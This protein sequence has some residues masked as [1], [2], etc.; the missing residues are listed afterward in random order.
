VDG[1]PGRAVRR[2][3]DPAERKARNRTVLFL[4]VLALINA[5]VFL[6]R[7]DGGL[8]GFGDTPSAAI[9]RSG[10]VL[11]PVADPVADACTGDPVRI[12]EGL[13]GLIALE[14][15]L[16]SGA[17]LR[18]ALLDRGVAS[19]EV[20]LIEA[21]VRSKVDLSLLGGSGAPVRLAVDRLGGVR[22]L[23]IEL[24]EGHLLQACRQPDGYAVRNIQHPLRVDV[25]VVAL[26]LAG[27]AD[28]AGAVERAGEHPELAAALA[29]TLAWDVD[30]QTEARP[31]DKI[32]VIVEKRWLGRSFHRYGP[33]LG[34][35]FV[36]AAGRVA[37]YRY[38]PPGRTGGFFDR[39]GKPMRRELRRTPVAYVRVPTEARGMLVPALEVVEGRVGAVYRV[40]EGTPVVALADGIIRDSGRH[41]DRGTFVDLEL[42]DGR[43][44]RYAHLLRTVGEL[45]PGTKIAEGRILGLA[46][47]TGKTPHDR[48][49]V[50]IL[51]ADG[52]S[53]DPMKMTAKGSAR[54]RHTGDP[55]P[56]G[57]LERYTEDI[58]SRGRALRLALR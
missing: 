22:A 1:K 45:E 33:I 16:S 7:G 49:R 17:T 26:E 21:S 53:L 41:E 30:F 15:S 57:A 27:D 40:P 44:V 20:E 9:G 58:A 19:E 18:L 35:R 34:V 51:D 43:T 13:E 23:E 6:W 32:A 24:A 42:S 36:G 28:L 56:E 55:V 54:P 38:K 50:E 48:V 12:F 31:G 4:G 47:H 14:T 10:G 46:G 29:D 3:P 39:H 37:Y 8:S 52:E 2:P 5:Y 11:R 25:E